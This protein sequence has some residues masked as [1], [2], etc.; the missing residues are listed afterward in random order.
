MTHPPQQRTPKRYLDPKVDLAFKRVFGEHANLLKSFLNALLPLP[1]DGLIDSLEYL[2]P[3]QAPQ[4]PGLSKF[5]I[6]DVKCTD[7]QGRI[8]IV[9]MQMMWSA[10]FEQ[11]MVFGASQAYVKQL[12]AGQRYSE[13]RPVYA[14]AIINSIFLPQQRDF[15][16]HYKIVNIEQPQQTLKGLEFVFIE[17][18]KFTPEDRAEKRLQ[19]LWLRFLREV[20]AEPAQIIDSA[21]TDEHDIAEALHLVEQSAFSEA[22]L[23]GYHIALDRARIE[24]SVLADAKAEGKA[25]GM[26]E[27]ERAKARTI[28]AAL[29]ASGTN[30]ER[31][32]ALT[33]LSLDDLR[34][35]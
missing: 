17:L 24:I 5:S 13:L 28:A 30:P 34:A 27:G 31:V 9:E 6:V 4:I 21:L 14:L 20:G 15:Y 35:L 11:R 3:E 22:E 32:A 26:V 8:F 29:L 16:H 23:D 7:Q 18:P 12:K 33:G 2:T 25:E 19:T 1:A 10:S